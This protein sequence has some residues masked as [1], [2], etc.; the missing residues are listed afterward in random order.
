M[1]AKGLEG[2][3]HVLMAY[4][5]RIYLEDWRKSLEN[6]KIASSLESIQF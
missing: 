6:L 4:Y 5:L 1:T 3:D 2:S